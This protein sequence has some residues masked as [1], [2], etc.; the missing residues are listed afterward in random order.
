MAKSPSSSASS[1]G[2]RPKGAGAPNARSLAGSVLGQKPSPPKSQFVVEGAKFLGIR[3][4]GEG[5]Q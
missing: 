5:K 3:P 1:R 2:E 4:K